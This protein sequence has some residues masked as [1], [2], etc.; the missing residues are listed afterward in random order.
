MK[1]RLCSSIITL[2]IFSVVGIANAQNVKN[3]IVDIKI[4]SPYEGE[5]IPQRIPVEGIVEFSQ[6]VDIDFYTLF[7][8]VQTSELVRYLSRW[9]GVV[10]YMKLKTIFVDGKYIAKWK[11]GDQ[12][13]LVFM[14]T[15]DEDAGNEF[16][17]QAIV[18]KA[19]DLQ[20]FKDKYYT[21]G[22]SHEYSK[23]YPHEFEKIISDFSQS[24]ISNP[25]KVKRE[26]INN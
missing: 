14:G 12:K 20:S 23:I 9:D 1:K 22:R 13:N 8:A 16:N 21:Y 10:Q 5:I 15:I 26:N 17:V 24:F 4:N 2:L 18:I 7:I 11:M 6:D 3:D 25:V 19:S